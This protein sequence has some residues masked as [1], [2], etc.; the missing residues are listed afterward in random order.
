[1]GTLRGICGATKK[2]IQG[3]KVWAGG[4]KEPFSPVLDEGS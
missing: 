2:L 4:Q 3:V 1:V